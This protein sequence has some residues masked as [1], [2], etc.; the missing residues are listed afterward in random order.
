MFRFRSLLLP[1]LVCAL[2]L[3]ADQPPAPALAINFSAV[4]VT[5]SAAS[6]H[7]Q[8]YIYSLA[9]EPRG[10]YTSVLQRDVQLVDTD[11]DGRVTWTFPKTVPPRS[12]WLA[13]DL[14]TGAAAVAPLPGYP[15]VRQTLD[16]N[17]L[18]NAVGDEIGALGAS[19]SLVAFIVV[20]P[21]DGV[22]G[23]AVGSRGPI[24]EGSENGKVTISAANLQPRVQTAAAAPSK[25]KKGDV[26][27]LINTFDSAYGMAI[28]GQ[29]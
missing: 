21:G 10:Y 25:L 12:V 9:R 4:G 15:A 27:F 2:P 22:W 7:S 8:V 13:V 17:N 28:V 3:F 16:S 19:G 5:I 23:A 29:K 6:P 24:D 18:K 11:G 20:R 1:L 14:S 26:V